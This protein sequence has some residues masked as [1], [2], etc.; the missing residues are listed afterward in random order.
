MI[1]VAGVG[2]VLLG[3]DGF[4]VEVVRRLKHRPLPPGT[5]VV[6]F[7]IRGLDLT[8]AL[9]D[10]VRAAIVVDA[11]PRGRAPGTLCVIE[12][13]VAAG[14]ATLELHSLDPGRVLQAARAL[15]AQVEQVR[16]VGCEPS[17]IASDDEALSAE[18]S[19]PVAAAVDEAVAI[20]ESLVRELSRA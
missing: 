2:N 18:L 5:R 15:G 4:G 17:R 12:P 3:D 14:P 16:V 13:A 11:M 9:L 19:A 8:Y 7:G 6:D 1:L 20:V 10:G